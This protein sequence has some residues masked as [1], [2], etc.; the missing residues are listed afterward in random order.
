LPFARSIFAFLLSM[1][2]G[3]SLLG[4]YIG[5]A[6][7]SSAP[8]HPFG[9]HAF[10]YTPGSIRPTNATASQL[11]EATRAFYESWKKRYLVAGCGTGRYYVFVNADGRATGI[12]RASISLSEGHGYGMM[13]TA[14][15][16]GH[17]PDAQRYFD[18]LY[19]FFK[20]HPSSVSPYLM[21]WNQVQGC[22]DLA[23]DHGADSATDGDLDIAYALLLADRQWGS[24]GA[25]NYLQEAKRV[26]AAVRQLELNPVSSVMLLGG[27]A[28]SS[29][30]DYYFGARSSD[31]M[32]DHFRS[33]HTVTGDARW[34]EVIEA[35]YRVIR[36]VQRRFSPQTGLVPDFIQNANTD[37]QPARPYYL[38]TSHDGHYS[39]NACRV[40]WRL[41]TDYFVSGDPRASDA[42][43]PINAWIR[44]AT[45][46]D[47]AL[48]HDGYDLSGTKVS[49]ETS[50]AFVAPLAVAAM[51]NADHQQWLNAQWR[52]MVNTPPSESDYYGNTI[53]MLSMIVISGN[54]WAP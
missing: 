7:G 23:D 37:P 42:V 5:R 30:P 38:E 51:V 36:S 32:P 44:R 35:G 19:N 2:V 3:A 12:T 16:A 31:F 46:G 4:P 48:I 15:M 17:D 9:A 20:D 8:Q 40:P 24:T 49:D 18:G 13:I 11:D 54:W 26:I 25:V 52:Y 22:R 33:F 6:A 10:A 14:L 27:F 47:P 43:D 53:K 28:R 29:S 39:Y 41:A 1:A 50:M 34:T 45:G 21:A